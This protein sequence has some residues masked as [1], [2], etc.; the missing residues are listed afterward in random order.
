[1]AERRV[2]FFFELPEGE[3]RK[4]IEELRTRTPVEN[5]AEILTYLRSGDEAG[6]VMTVEEDVLSDA[7]TII[8]PVHFLTDGEWVWP[9]SLSYYVNKYDVT[10]PS[11]FVARIFAGR[12]RD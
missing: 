4:Q 1:M 6:V 11:D 12:G 8:G 3:R 7:R 2:G 5:K 9:E 10:L